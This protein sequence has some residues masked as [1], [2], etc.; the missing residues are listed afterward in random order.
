[1]VAGGF[2]DTNTTEVFDFGTNTWAISAIATPFPY[3][4]GLNRLYGTHGILYI[5]GEGS[6]GQVDTILEYQGA[7]EEWV[8]RAEKLPGPR[9]ELTGIIIPNGRIRC[10]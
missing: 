2:P 6:S 7:T 4:V 9:K 10:P 3:K 8:I 1:M 5:G